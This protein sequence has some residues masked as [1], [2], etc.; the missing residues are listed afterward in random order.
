MQVSLTKD[1][2]LIMVEHLVELAR[3]NARII[4]SVDEYSIFN[5]KHTNVHDFLNSTCK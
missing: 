4:R 3:I 1:K 2:A 5:E